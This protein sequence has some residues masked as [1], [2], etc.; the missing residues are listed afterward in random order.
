VGD[1][2]KNVCWGVV[3]QAGGNKCLNRGLEGLRDFAD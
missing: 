1:L 3:F 2:V